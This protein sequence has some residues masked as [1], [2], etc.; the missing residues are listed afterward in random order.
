MDRWEVYLQVLEHILKLKTSKST[1]PGYIPASLIKCYAEYICVP[2]AN[3][4]NTCISRGEYPK[5]WK[6]EIQTPIPKEYPPVKVE[7]LR[8]ISNLKN[9]DKVSEM[10]LGE[11]ILSDMS[12]KLD[13]SQYGNKKRS[14]SAT[15]PYE[16]AASNLYESGQ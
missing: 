11:L 14:F 5:I 10:M 1:L 16:N 8:N 7:L 13:L 15:L 4:L 6:M 2:L 12:S 3:V 9:F